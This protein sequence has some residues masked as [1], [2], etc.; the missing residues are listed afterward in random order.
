MSSQKLYHYECKN[1][2][3][4]RTYAL[5]EVVIT[6]TRNRDKWYAWSQTREDCV[7]TRVVE[8][9]VDRNTRKT[10]RKQ[11]VHYKCGLK[12]C[13]RSREDICHC[14]TPFDW[15]SRPAGFS[16]DAVSPEFQ[17]LLDRMSFDEAFARG[18]RKIA[19]DYAKGLRSGTTGTGVDPDMVELE[20][21][22]GISDIESE[23]EDLDQESPPE[24]ELVA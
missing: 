3:C 19:R 24:E 11:V 13:L 8:V 20:I 1:P 2:K 17:D 10:V 23:E 22:T 5:P 21:E 9:M 15:P 18:V 4:N 7:R 6:G 14:G 12:P 16:K